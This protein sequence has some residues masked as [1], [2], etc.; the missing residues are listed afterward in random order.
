[1]LTL[2]G[3]FAVMIA[4]LTLAILSPGPAIIAAMQTAFARG[5][6][7]ALPYG[8]GLAVGASLWCLFALAGLTVLFQLVPALYIALKIFGGLYLLWMAWG[9]WRSAP[10]PM[11][12]AAKARFGTGFWGGIAL[13][14]SNPKPA[15]FY[16]SLIV[17]L[18]PGPLSLAGQAAI[19]ATALG[20]EL[21]WYVVVTTAMSTAPLRR[22][23]A[24]AKLWLDRGAAVLLGLLGLGLI[25]ETL[26]EAITETV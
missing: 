13:N 19:Y 21:F 15:L 5:R 17:A 11:P 20:T 6:E 23:Y 1:M 26:R 12:E 25:A 2:A 3:P 8:V 4:T 14:L 7:V 9:L 22:R 16:S 10:H 18:F 24:A